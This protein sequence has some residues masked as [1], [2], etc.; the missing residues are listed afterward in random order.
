MLEYMS[1]LVVMQGLCLPPWQAGLSGVKTRQIIEKGASMETG[2]GLSFECRLTQ[3]Q[4][5]CD[6]LMIT[7]MVRLQDGSDHGRMVTLNLV[8]RSETVSSHT[9]WFGKG[10]AAPAELEGL[11]FDCGSFEYLFNTA[12]GKGDLFYYQPAFSA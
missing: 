9:V 1:I 3:A 4:M 6:R 10:F 5:E 8:T 7:V 2:L 12:E 11:D